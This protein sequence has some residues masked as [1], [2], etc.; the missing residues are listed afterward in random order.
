[1]KKV[2]QSN[3]KLP[4]LDGDNLNSLEKIANDFEA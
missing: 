1:M 2:L 3:F 4:R